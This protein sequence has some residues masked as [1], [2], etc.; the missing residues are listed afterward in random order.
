MELY[1]Y[2]VQSISDLNDERVNE[3]VKT[4]KLLEFSLNIYHKLIHKK[5]LKQLEDKQVLEQEI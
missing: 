5:A 2:F 4:F 3:W 1:A